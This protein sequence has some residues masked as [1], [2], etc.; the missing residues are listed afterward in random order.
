[1]YVVKRWVLILAA[2]CALLAFQEEGRAQSLKEKGLKLWNKLMEPNRNLDSAY[3]FQPFKGW[4]VST[5]YQGRWDNVGLE[6]PVLLSFSSFS[7]EA[8]VSVNMIKNQS[9]HVGLHGGYG[10]ITLGYSVAVGTRDKPDK[11]FSFDWL[12]NSFGFQFYYIRVHD[13]ATSFLSYPNTEPVALPEAPSQGHILRLSGYYAFNNKKFSYPSAYQGKMVQRKSAGSFMAGLKFHHAN[14]SLEDPKSI[15]GS[16]I[17]DVTGY[18][19][20]QFS[21]GAGYSYNWVLYHRDAESSHDLRKLR[22]VT[23]NITAIPLLTVV[24]EMRMTHVVPPNADVEIIPVHGGIQ[25]NGLG[26]V[27]LCYAIGHFYLTSNFEFHYHQFRS[28][29]ITKSDLDESFPKDYIYKFSVLGHLYNWTASL[30]LHYR[31]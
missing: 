9:H 30:E 6:I 10:P 2:G 26:K 21:L 3:V 5:S 17:L 7:T 19:T 14:L 20:Y 4:N 16:L 29:E 12:S 25:P 15:L 13:T 27:A 22:N 24:N 8:N 11:H 18:S 31:F 23:F 1:M 28:K